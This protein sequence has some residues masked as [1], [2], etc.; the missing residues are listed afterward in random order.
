VVALSVGVARTPTTCSVCDAISGATAARS[1]SGR[2]KRDV[3]S[4]I[5]L[6]TRSIRAVT[7][8]PSRVRWILPLSAYSAAVLRARGPTST[9]SWVPS[10]AARTS[11][12]MPLAR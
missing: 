3:H 8:S 12:A 5:P 7:D 6:E 10:S 9:M 4:T 1:R 11:S 2:F